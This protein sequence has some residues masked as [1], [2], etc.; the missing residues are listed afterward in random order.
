MVCRILSTN[1]RTRNLLPPSQFE[2]MFLSTAHTDEDIEKT[3]HA[4][5]QAFKQYKG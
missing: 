2:G 4:A 1:G 5:E 3:V